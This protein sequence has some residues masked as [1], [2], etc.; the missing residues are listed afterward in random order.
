MDL[1][2]IPIFQLGKTEPEYI[3]QCNCSLVMNKSM[4]FE[5]YLIYERPLNLL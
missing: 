5:I 1:C 3:T 2:Y 4:E